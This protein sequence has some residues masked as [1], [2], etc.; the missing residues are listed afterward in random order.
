MASFDAVVFP[1]DISFGSQGGPEFLTR[2]VELGGGTE[3]RDQRWEYPRER[4]NVAY[5]VR[6]ETQLDALMTFFY[7]RRGRAAG[8]LFWNHRDHSAVAAVI[9]TGNAV[10][11]AFQLYKTYTSGGVV[12]SRKIR[13]PKS[14]TLTITLNGSPTTAW[15]CDYATGIVTFTAPPANGAVIAAT[16]DFYVPMRFDAD[17]CPSRLEDY[18][19]E[20]AEVQLLEIRS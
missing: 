8:F 20:S 15:T 2:I 18:K 12:F 13:K 9:G 6:E 4:W 7:C 10:T 11:Q 5:G 16:F 17:Y 19:A 14:G 3:Q 1:T